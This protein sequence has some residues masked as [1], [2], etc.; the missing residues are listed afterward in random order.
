MVNS[1]NTEKAK[2]TVNLCRIVKSHSRLK[3]EKWDCRE[4]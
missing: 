3:P 1:K 2:N 4:I